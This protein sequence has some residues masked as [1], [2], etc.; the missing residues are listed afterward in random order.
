[1]RNNMHWDWWTFIIGY[2][3]GGIVVGLA[4]IG[5]WFE[6]AKRAQDMDDINSP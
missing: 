1:M 6:L 2:L 4:L 5:L 3:T